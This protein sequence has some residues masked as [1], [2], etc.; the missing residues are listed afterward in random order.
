MAGWYIICFL[1]LPWCLSAAPHHS[2]VINMKTFLGLVQKLEANVPG[3]SAR[4]LAQ[5]L[6]SAITPPF[7]S[8]QFFSDELAA[9]TRVLLTH[10]VQGSE[11]MGW[12]EQ[13][14]VLAPDGS[15]V[16]LIPLLGAMIR[17]WKTDCDWKHAECSHKNLEHETQGAEGK[18]PC[19][20][21]STSSDQQ[22]PSFATGSDSI[23][24]TSLA[25]LLGMGFA[26]PEVSLETPLDV[27]D[28]CWDSISAPK[29]F[30]L[31]GAPSR[32]GMTMAYVN[33]A[34]DGT[35]LGLMM[36]NETQN[37]SSL[38][39]SYY[40]GKPTMSSYRRQ[41]FQ[42]LLEEG[43]LEEE[44]HRGIDC[45]RKYAAS[46]GLHHITDNLLNTTAAAAA[47]EFEERYLE[48][49]AVIPRCMWEA[50]PYKGTPTPLQTPLANIYIHHTYEP[51]KPCASFQDCAADM[52]SMQRF[53]QQ[54]RGWDDIGYSFVAG[55]DGYLYEGRGWHWVGAHTKGHNF[56]GYGVSFIGNFMSS[57]PE[58]RIMN[59][60]KDRFLKCAVRS[61]YISSN[62]TL[63]GHRQVGITS[64]PGDAL[65][66]EITSWDHFKET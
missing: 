64:C 27:T 38:I 60:V 32:N 11:D 56:I 10:K 13:G 55:S 44:I 35:L 53:H 58:S 51:S 19:P 12:H 66:Q 21:N 7:C 48:C 46:C 31:Q 8:L 28:G 62:Y 49:P 6:L 23:H 29:Y 50:K 47:R 45:Y 30:Q 24:P 65:Y 14:V 5:H 33:G 43:Q 1:M 59:L 34:L 36:T 41:N 22:R 17:G 37:M 42:A 16:A 63:Q 15:T 52:R 4:D 61:G 20:Q 26:D 9:L 25:I 3:S 40:W 2:H 39:Q 18:H 57:V 54:D